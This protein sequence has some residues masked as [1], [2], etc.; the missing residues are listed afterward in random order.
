MRLMYPF[1]YTAVWSISFDCRRLRGWAAHWSSQIISFH[2]DTWYMYIVFQCPFMEL[3]QIHSGDLCVGLKLYKRWGYSLIIISRTLFLI[4]WYRYSG[5][6]MRV[7]WPCW[8]TSGAKRLL[9]PPTP[10]LLSTPFTPS[11]ISLTMFLSRS[12]SCSCCLAVLPVDQRALVSC[13]VRT[14]S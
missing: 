14:I 9:Q 6:V 3:P 5:Y 4:Y 8:R 7:W 1:V 12:G 13:E 10:Q 2:H 11:V